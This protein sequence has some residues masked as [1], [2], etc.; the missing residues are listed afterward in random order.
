MAKIPS[1]ESLGKIYSVDLLP[2]YI[3]FQNNQTSLQVSIL[4]VY[5][6]TQV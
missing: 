5:K 3:F 2:Y 6:L 4:L 1:G